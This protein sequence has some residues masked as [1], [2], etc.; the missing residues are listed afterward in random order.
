MLFRS[1]ILSSSVLPHTQYSYPT[2]YSHT[3]STLSYSVLPPDTVLPLYS[4]NTQYTQYSHQT[5]YCHTLSTPSHSLLPPDLV[6]YHTQYAHNIFQLIQRPHTQFT[7]FDQKPMFIH[8]LK[9]VCT[10]GVTF[11]E[12]ILKP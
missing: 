12:Y 5:E 9:P 8:H 3:L 11:A 4:L 7:D 2:Q 1:Q 10:T 6:L